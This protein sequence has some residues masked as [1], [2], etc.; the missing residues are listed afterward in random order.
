[1][2]VLFFSFLVA[3]LAQALS[4]VTPYTDRVIF[5]PPSNWR[6]VYARSLLIANDG[7]DSNV[8]LTTWANQSPRPPNPWFPVYRSTDLGQTWK[9]LSNI[10][11][12]QN[13]WGLRSQPFLFELPSAF[14]SFPAGTIL[15]AGNSIP[16]D[17]SQTRIDVYASPDKGR[18]W[19]FVSHVALGGRADP[20]NGQTPVWEPFFFVY[21]G[22]LVIYY[23]D[24]R[25]PSE[26]GQKLVHQ[27]TSDLL[28]WGPV[29]DDV[30]DANPAD[31]PG[32]TTI[33]ALP[34][35]KYIMTYEFGGAPEIDF[36]VYYRISDSP[37]TFINATGHN[38]RATTGEQ[39]QSS[40]VVVWTPFGGPNGTIVVSENSNGGLWTNKQLGAAG[41]PWTLVPTG[42]SVSYARD[43]TVLPT[44]QQI[45]ITGGG[46][47]DGSEN[48]VLASV[49]DLS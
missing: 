8:L 11:D 43:L 13:G 16:A 2:L 6:V 33:A 15:A 30:A 26:H 45:L 3:G 4:V 21:E 17:S 18:T 28:N 47:F 14:G 32:M 22:Q 42:A 35:G 29:V 37:L 1:M 25:D 24:Q 39:T 49:I 34:N 41:S 19:Q 46:T 36:A 10:T 40:P 5:S 12:T 20:T 9:P 38:I 48:R 27:V 23:S 31:R 44:S 7:A